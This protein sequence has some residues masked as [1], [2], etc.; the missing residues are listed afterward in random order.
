MTDKDFYKENGYLIFNTNIDF[1]LINSVIETI[2]YK[3][4]SRI[5]DA[6]ITNQ[7]VKQLALHDNIFNK[8]KELYNKEPL[9]FQTLNFNKGTQQRIHSDTIHFNSYPSGNMCGVWIALEDITDINGPLF[10][11]PGSHKEPELN[12]QNLG[13]KNGADD[14]SLY[15]IMIQKIIDTKDYDKFY[16]IMPK[17]YAIIWA[18]NLLHGGSE[19]KDKQAT[20]HSQVTHYFFESEYYWTPLLST[21]NYIYRQPA[22]IK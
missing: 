9:P 10:Y 7:Y 4:N 19:V 14:Y 16:G 15:E 6:W 2:D 18:S 12:M 22:F 5:Q 1:K 20:R 11:Y 21:T 17:G 8:I 3:S 13:L